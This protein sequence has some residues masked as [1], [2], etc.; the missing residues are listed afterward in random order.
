MHPPSIGL[1]G[2]KQTGKSTVGEYLREAHGYHVSAFADP[3]RAMCRQVDPLVAAGRRYS[4]VEAMLGYEGAKE[5]PEFRG[6]LQR[7]GVA[8]RETLG[9]DV[10][11]DAWAASVA[12]LHGVP[13]VVTDVRF[14][15]EA[16]ALWKR[17][18]ILIRTTRKATYNPRERH[19]SET[20][21]DY[22][23]ADYTIA[24]DGTTSQLLDAVEAALT[25]YS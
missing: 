10:W 15:N 22:Y 16:E 14:P 19:I 9:A 11:V 2:R 12:P 6:T 4:E 5:L 13:I 1:I 8:A 24:N 25:I 3:L 17:G 20:G 7:V 21:L 18:F 23:P